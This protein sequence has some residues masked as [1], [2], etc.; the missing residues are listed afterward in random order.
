MKADNLTRDLKGEEAR[1]RSEMADL[2][3]EVASAVGDA[4]LT[5]ACIVFGAPYR[6]VRGGGFSAWRIRRGTRVLSSRA[7]YSGWE[8]MGGGGK[9]RCT[10][11]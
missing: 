2:R 1:W 7:R 6:C 3:A 8:V 5:A 4:A 11:Y 9:L 10:L